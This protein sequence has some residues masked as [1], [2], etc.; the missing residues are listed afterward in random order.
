LLLK[1][2]DKRGAIGLDG[3]DPR[4]HYRHA[5]NEDQIADTGADFSSMECPRGGVL[6]GELKKNCAGASD[7]TFIFRLSW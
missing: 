3:G 4:L 5:K 6:M 1:Q 7:L 2:D